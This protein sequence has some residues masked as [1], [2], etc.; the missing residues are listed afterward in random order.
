MTGVEDGEARRL[1]FEAMQRAADAD[2]KISVHE[3]V[4]AERYE[5]INDKL[6][7]LRTAGDQRRQAI[8]GIYGLLWTVA[9]SFIL[10][11]MALVGYFFDRSFPAIGH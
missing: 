10:L 2:V 1:A 6:D 8:R 9:G 5:N 4:C 7:E 11:L 3:R